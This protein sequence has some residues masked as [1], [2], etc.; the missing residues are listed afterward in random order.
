MKTPKS[1]QV[2]EYEVL[3]IGQQGFSKEHF[4]RLAIYQEERQSPFFSIG[5][6]AIR[7]SN[8]VGVFQ[9]QD[10]V[11]EV[12]PKA[13]RNNDTEL[14]QNVLLDMLK[15]SGF[16][17]VKSVSDSNLRLK[18][19]TLLN[20][21]FEVYLSY[22]RTIIAEG[23]VHRYSLRNF[24]HNVLKGRI[25]FSDQLKHNI[26][27]K[28]R[29]FTNCQEYSI[30]NIYNQILFKALRILSSVS[31]S[32]AQRRDASFILQ[33]NDGIPDIQCT[34]DLFLRL[35]Y[36][37]TTERYR[38]AL[39]LAELIILNYQPDLKSGRRSVFAIL[40]PMEALFESYVIHVLTQ[41]ARQTSL[42]ILP[43]KRKCFW[44]SEI[45]GVKTVRPDIV[46]DF[47]G[48]FK[49]KRIILDTKWKLPKNH[50]PADSDLKQ[51]F[52][53]NKIFNAESSNLVY[54]AITSSI[55]R[56]GTFMGNEHGDCS[57]WFIPI[58]NLD[59]NKLNHK[60]GEILL[61]QIVKS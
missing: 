18:N 36:E 57:M 33:Q 19:G 9:V 16:L 54:P 3:R 35:T 28:E 14:W 7:F 10:L 27:R 12:L 42:N 50:L 59:E 20:L 44:R 24:N 56:K 43:Q 47:V 55:T 17:N 5:H 23:L 45:K 8:Y 53:Y 49:K 51:M 61:S 31:T 30:N 6:N 4:E 21:F 41:A 39:R 34:Q 15:V 52:V 58:L 46:I 13:G 11:I 22:C 38:A 1:I 48:D 32:S 2:F 25:I 29:F 60:L 37:R 26:I 40:F